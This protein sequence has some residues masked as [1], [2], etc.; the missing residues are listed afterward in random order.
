[1][2]IVK[3]TDRATATNC[4]PFTRPITTIGITRV[5]SCPDIYHVF[6]EFTVSRNEC[7]VRIGLVEAGST[8]AIEGIGWWASRL[9][10]LRHPQFS[11]LFPELLRRVASPSPL[12]G[13]NA[14]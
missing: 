7:L 9:V 11:S 14:V 10:P 5:P 12:I 1:M 13:L 8:V 6:C 2:Y 4:H 3:D